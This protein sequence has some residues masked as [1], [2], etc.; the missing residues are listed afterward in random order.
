LTKS[1]ASCSIISNYS[2]NLEGKARMQLRLLGTESGK[3]GCPAL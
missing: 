3:E 1:A 2:S